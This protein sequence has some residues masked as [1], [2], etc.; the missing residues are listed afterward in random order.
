M[1]AEESKMDHPSPRMDA[2]P[3]D[4]NET[5]FDIFSAYKWSAQQQDPALV[6]LERKVLRDSILDTPIYRVLQ[7][8]LVVE[9]KTEQS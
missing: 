9:A 7:E 2:P 5:I 8:L 6:A 1:M 3:V 4:N